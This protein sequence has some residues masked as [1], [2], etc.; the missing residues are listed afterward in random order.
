MKFLFLALVFSIVLSGCA[1]SNEVPVTI[2]VTD[3]EGNQ[4]DNARIVF[5]PYNANFAS[6]VVNSNS[7]GHSISQIIPGSYNITVSKEG[8]KTVVLSM[9]ISDGMPRIEVVIEEAG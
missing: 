5:S 1:V 4:I 3:V 9:E 8:Y 7:R 6:N 2:S